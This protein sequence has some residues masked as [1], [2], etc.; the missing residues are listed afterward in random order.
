MLRSIYSELPPTPNLR[1]YIDCFWVNDSLK[2]TNPIIKNIYP[3]SC[4]DLIVYIKN[5]TINDIIL[6]G[7]WDKPFQ[8]ETKPDDL[9]VGVRFHLP[10]ILSFFNFPFSK[11]KNSYT[12]FEESMLRRCDKDLCNVMYN[13]KSSANIIYSLHN[14]FKTS[15][16]IISI[17]ERNIYL[18]FCKN[19]ELN[20][21]SFISKEIGLSSRQ[22][23][24]VFSNDL[25]I[26]TKKYLSIRKFKRAKALLENGTPFVQ[27]AMI[28]NYFDQAHFIKNFRKYSGIT[29]SNYLKQMSDFN[30]AWMVDRLH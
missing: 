22:L 19:A 24:R 13:C 15:L 6:T 7:F 29:P 30:S 4:F 3:D 2:L 1:D 23:N 25:G 9:I 12:I 27:V 17:N 11:I 5:N 18:D 16:G 20:I 14:Y 21:V 10:S 26:N 28:C 8:V